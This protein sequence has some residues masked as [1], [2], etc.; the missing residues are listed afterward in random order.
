MG[1]WGKRHQGTPDNDNQSNLI[2]IRTF[3]G[4]G[5]RLIPECVL[6]LILL[7][8]FLLICDIRVG[9]F[10]GEQGVDAFSFHF[11]QLQ[12]FGQAA[13]AGAFVGVGLAVDGEDARVGILEAVLGPGCKA[14]GEEGDK[15]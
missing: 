13:V 2:E 4:A 6:T 15:H 11:A 5:T 9:L 1:R 8:I 12:E 3:E 7:S 10:A 14:A